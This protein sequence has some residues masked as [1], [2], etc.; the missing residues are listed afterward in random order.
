MEKPTKKP[1]E[2]P[3]VV[4]KTLREIIHEFERAKNKKE[5]LAKN[6]KKYPSLALKY[7]E[8]LVNQ[9]KCRGA[10]SVISKWRK[11]IM[12][13]PDYNYVVFKIAYCLFMKKE[14]R[15]LIYLCDMEKKNR[16]FMEDAKVICGYPERTTYEAIIEKIFKDV[17]RSA[18]ELEKLKKEL[19]K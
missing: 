5:F 13:L 6:V 15:P 10:L 7:A 18:G 3:K 17:E 11:E 1:E 8:F 2:K 4:K 16:E 19:G 12:F 14:L 9:E